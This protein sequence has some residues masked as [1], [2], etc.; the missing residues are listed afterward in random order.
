MKNNLLSKCPI[1]SENIS[2][3]KLHCKSCSTS[4][5]GDFSL[6]SFCHLGSEQKNFLKAFIKCRGNIKEMEKELNISYPTVKNRLEHLATSLGFTT[7]SETQDNHKEILTKLNE[8]E[9]TSEEAI[10]LLNNKFGG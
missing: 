5:E 10:K 4:I 1:C 8:G 7:K 3:K 9:I 2:V 6:C